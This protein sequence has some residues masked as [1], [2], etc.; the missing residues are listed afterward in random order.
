MLEKQKTELERRQTT[1]NRQLKKL[2]L[3]KP[4]R[5]YGQEVQKLEE[6]LSKYR[7]AVGVERAKK[8]NMR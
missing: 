2:E 5:N 1:Q 4:E 8:E 7:E 6:L 3:F